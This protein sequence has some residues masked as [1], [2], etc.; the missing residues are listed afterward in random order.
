MFDLKNES[1]EDNN[2]DISENIE[3]SENFITKL[4][5]K[6]I[7]FSD[8]LSDQLEKIRLKNSINRYFIEFPQETK[9]FQILNI[10][11]I[12]DIEPLKKI[13]S[14][15]SSYV[16]SYNTSGIL[17]TI[18]FEGCHFTEKLGSKFGYNIDGFTE[19][20]KKNPEVDKIIKEMMIQIG[21]SVSL[22]P[23]VRLLHTTI[24]TAFFTY[25]I[26]KTIIKDNKINIDE[27]LKNNVDKKII[28]K[29][30]DL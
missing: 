5:N 10:D 3:N 22:P 18:Y 29:F 17:K 15:I 30:K 21:A 9:S 8:N 19:N 11:N 2:S 26:N 27:K 25:A 1:V 28:E 13:F 14:E 12:N 23:H 20:L 24:K 6:E 4:E 16:E 7:S